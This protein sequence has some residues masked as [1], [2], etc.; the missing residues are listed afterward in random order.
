MQSAM[1]W[2]RWVKK[3]LMV[4]GDD[5]QHT[6]ETDNTTTTPSIGRNVV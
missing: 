1:R 2:R 3:V 4:E 5:I 6:A